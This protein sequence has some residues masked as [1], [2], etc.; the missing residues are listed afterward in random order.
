MTALLCVCFVLFKF[1][2]TTNLCRLERA[3]QT[4]DPDVCLAYW[5]S[6]LDSYMQNISDS[7]LWTADYMGN[8]NGT[9]NIGPFAGWESPIGC[10]DPYPQL[11]R[12]VGLYDMGEP[13]TDEKLNYIWDKETYESIVCYVDCFFEDNHGWVHVLVAGHMEGIACSPSDPVFFIH[14]GFIDFIWEEFR[15]NSQVTDPELEYPYHVFNETNI[16]GQSHDPDAPMQPFDFLF[17]IHGL[18]DHYVN[19]YYTYAARPI[20]CEEE[21]DC[22]S[23]ILWCDVTE[24]EG[25]CKA[26]VMEGGNCVGLPDQACACPIE[27]S[28]PV[29][30]DGVCLC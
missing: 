6:T 15:Q 5:D 4:H 12:F 18:S 10:R 22:Q 1:E 3:L 13:F 11:T 26:K 19:Y 8:P 9:V 20:S 27:G 2:H 7:A 23:A 28:N 16:G 25:R 14:H 24:E 21:S 30:L 29:C 17:N